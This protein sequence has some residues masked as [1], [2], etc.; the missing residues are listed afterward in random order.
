MR[1]L[2]THAADKVRDLYQIAEGGRPVRNRQTRV[3]AGNESSSGDDDKSCAGD[4][5]SEGVVCAIVR[6]GE[7]VQ[8]RAPLAGEISESCSGQCGI[9][10]DRARDRRGFSEGSKTKSPLLAKSARSGAPGSLFASCFE[11]LINRLAIFWSD[12]DLLILLAQLFVDECQCVVSR[13]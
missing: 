1:P 5:D 8:N 11:A 12:S 10:A 9:L 2:I 6:C 4:E 7:G 13:R 3:I